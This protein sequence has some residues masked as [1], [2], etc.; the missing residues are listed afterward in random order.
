MSEA[1]ILISG[2]SGRTGAAAVDELL[3]MGKRVRAYV[4]S[5]D[6]RA[7]ALRHRGVD[8]AIG[9]FTDMDDIRAAMQGVHSAYFLHPIAPGIIAAAAYFAQAAKEAGV[10][11]IVNMSQI[12]ARRE[13]TSHAAQDHWISE[14]V[15]DWSGVHSRGP[16]S[17]AGPLE[18]SR[19]GP[20]REISRLSSIRRHCICE[21]KLSQ[22]RTVN[23]PRLMRRSATFR[24]SF[25]SFRA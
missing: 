5:N 3:T 16:E 22:R 4:R 25:G 19:L 18:R 11:A 17:G 10:P 14:R 9:D 23:L 2:A 1:D 24:D 13:S 8:V 15:F 21:R 6:A 20:L 7:A 12:S